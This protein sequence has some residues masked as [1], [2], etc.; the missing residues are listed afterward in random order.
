MYQVSPSANFVHVMGCA[1]QM[2][3][4]HEVTTTNK[5]VHDMDTM[6]GSAAEFSAVVRSAT[7]PA[8]FPVRVSSGGCSPIL[9]PT[10][11]QCFARGSPTF[12]TGGGNVR[13]IK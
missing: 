3:H 2:I 9:S 4:E 8:A 1:F 13:L 10:L 11:L 7:P 6:M 5:L 12:V